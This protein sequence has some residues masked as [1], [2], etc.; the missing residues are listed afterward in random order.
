VPASNEALTA[1]FAIAGG[2]AACAAGMSTNAA[3]AAPDAIPVPVMIFFT[4]IP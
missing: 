3:D 1:T 2:G 4:E